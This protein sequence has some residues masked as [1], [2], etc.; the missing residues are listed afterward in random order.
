MAHE[1][2]QQWKHTSF[3]ERKALFH[4]MADVIEAGIEKYAQLQTEE[5]GMLYSASKS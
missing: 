4:K 1:A 2:F 3:D 5:M